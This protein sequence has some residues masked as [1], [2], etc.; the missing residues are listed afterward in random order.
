MQKILMQNPVYFGYFTFQFTLYASEL[1]DN[2]I[3]YKLLPRF[4]GLLK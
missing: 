1:L 2:N 3:L 4:W